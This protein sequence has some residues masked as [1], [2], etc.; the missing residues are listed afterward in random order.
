MKSEKNKTRRKQSADISE[1][2]TSRISYQKRVDDLI[3]G[4]AAD[5][6]A[7]NDFKLRLAQ[8]VKAAKLDMKR[9]RLVIDSTNLINEDSCRK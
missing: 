6:T 2:E 4:A 9:D 5:G 3:S 7:M 8:K 1:K